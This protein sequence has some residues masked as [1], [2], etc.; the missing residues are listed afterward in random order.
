MPTH[1]CS[2]RVSE[3]SAQFDAPA[4]RQSIHPVMAIFGHTGKAGAMVVESRG[5]HRAHL[6]ASILRHDHGLLQLLRLP[7]PC[8][9]HLNRQSGFLP[10]D[11]II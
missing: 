2:N 3:K 8:S 7:A 10:R 11:K 6:L 1:S 4:C 5:S 9:H